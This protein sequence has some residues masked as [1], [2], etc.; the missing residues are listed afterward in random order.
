MDTITIHSLTRTPATTI[1]RW[2]QHFVIIP[3]DMGGEC[4]ISYCTFQFSAVNIS[5]LLVGFSRQPFSAHFL[6]QETLLPEAHSQQHIAVCFLFTTG[7]PHIRDLQLS[8]CK[9]LFGNE[10]TSFLDL[11][12]QRVV[13]WLPHFQMTFTMMPSITKIK[14]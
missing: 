7:K 9:K 11:F 14:F 4:H 3:H 1:H 6:Q 2:M 5:D 13:S 12:L 10:V 8:L